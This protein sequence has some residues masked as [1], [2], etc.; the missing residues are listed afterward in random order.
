[1]SSRWLRATLSALSLP[2]AAVVLLLGVPVV[3]GV[4][5]TA[6]GER[7]AT[8]PV[9]AVLGLSALW[10]VGLWAYTFV[11]TASLPGLT[12]T[13]A[14]TLNAVGSAVSNLLPFG[15]AA[16]VATTFVMAGRWG[17]RPA[18][19]A[20]SAL[21]TGIWNTLGRLALPALGLVMLVLSGHIAE[22]RLTLAVI[23]VSGLLLAGLL[24]VLAALCREAAGLRLGAAADLL[25]RML[26]RAWRPAPGRVGRHLVGLRL[27]SIDLVR[28]EWGRLSL[29]VA[30]YLGLQALLFAACLHI[31]GADVTLV[32]MFAGFALGRVLTLIVA[33]P[34]G[35]GI[36]E[37]GTTA[38]LVA[39]GAAPA[40][41]A[42]GVL[43]FAVFT[44]VLEI[45]LGGAVWAVWRVSSCRRWRSSRRRRSVP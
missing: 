2:V 37:T 38:L 18:A 5:W 12:H 19:V 26:P 1:M 21:V 32:E 25:A 23:A 22:P 34:G 7:L 4:G 3:T 31:T 30:A 35:S 13:Q 41:T 6:I 44:F 45:P 39:L 20:V 33:T 24:A 9:P 11:L 10:L 42:A 14:F 17:L 15:G 27:A 16:G 40:A 8:L 43:L 28:R 36:S 29:G